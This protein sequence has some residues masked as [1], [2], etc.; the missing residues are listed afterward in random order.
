MAKAAS[1]TP[2]TPSSSSSSSS[3]PCTPFCLLWHPPALLGQRKVQKKAYK[4]EWKVGR[5]Y[6]D[7]GNDKVKI[8]ETKWSTAVFAMFS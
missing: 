1:T 3:S 8:L 4:T 7:T 6:L 5:L 2:T